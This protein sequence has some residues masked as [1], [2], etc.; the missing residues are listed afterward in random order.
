MTTPHQCG[1]CGS[2]VKM[3][4]SADIK[5]S[6]AERSELVRRSVH[7]YEFESL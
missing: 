1:I 4:E 2:I 7:F 6:P 3:L 5:F